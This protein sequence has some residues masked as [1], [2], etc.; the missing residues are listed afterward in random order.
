MTANFERC[1]NYKKS[2]P[3]YS[4]NLKLLKNEMLNESDL[5]DN[6][7]TGLSVYRAQVRRK[8]LIDRGTEQ[9]RETR[10]RG[11]KE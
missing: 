5:I 10:G 3:S 1:D 11:G 7:I 4:E 9:E 8:I 2:K 6:C